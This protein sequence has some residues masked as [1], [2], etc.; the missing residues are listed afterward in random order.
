MAAAASSAFNM[1]NFASALL[2][3]DQQIKSVSNAMA[4]ENTNEGKRKLKGV[5]DHLLKQK[6]AAMR[7]QKAQAKSMATRKRSAKQAEA[8]KRLNEMRS[9]KRSFSQSMGR[10]ARA[11]AREAKKNPNLINMEL[12]YQNMGRPGRSAQYGPRFSRATLNA[13]RKHPY[14]SVTSNRSTQKKVKSYAAHLREQEE[15]QKQNMM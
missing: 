3:I 1:S 9:A 5:F 8:R 2:N 12:S 15:E 6:K 11:A 10:H 14:R 4:L 7:Q 13:A